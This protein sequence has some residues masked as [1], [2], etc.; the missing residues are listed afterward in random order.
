MESSVTRA[1]RRALPPDAAR[2]E[3][4]AY[5]SALVESLARMSRRG[6]MPTLAYLLDIARLEAE[7][8]ARAADDESRP[9]EKRVG[10]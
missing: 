3:I 6:G 7:T 10:S 8:H 5:V 1:A 9:S 2:K 4:A